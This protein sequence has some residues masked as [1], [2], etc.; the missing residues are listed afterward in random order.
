MI[1]GQV[2]VIV[3]FVGFFVF[4]CVVTPKLSE[5]FSLR[6]FV[7]SDN[8]LMETFDIADNEFNNKNGINIDIMMDHR[9]ASYSVSSQHCSPHSSSQQRPSLHIHSF[10]SRSRVCIFF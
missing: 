7:P 4:G 6:F 8:P 3:V 2:V 10:A 9:P 5:N 1:A